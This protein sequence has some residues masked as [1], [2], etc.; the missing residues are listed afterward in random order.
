M[1]D[2]ASTV[3]NFTRF[4]TEQGYPSKLLWTSP[5]FVLYWRRRFFVLAVDPEKC[6]VQAQADFEAATARNVGVAIEGKCKTG[7]TTICRVYVPI[8]STDAQ[9]RLIPEIGVK[10]TVLRDPLPAIV[11]RNLFRWRILKRLS[12]GS[13]ALWD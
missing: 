7:T 1:A 10:M 9:Y 6:R 5:D 3:T 11:V 13:A 4:A 8:D 12:R 2:F